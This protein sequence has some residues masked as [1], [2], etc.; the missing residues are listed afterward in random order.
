MNNLAKLLVF[1]FMLSGCATKE[2]VHEYVQSQLKPVNNRTVV[3]ENRSNAADAAI[4][5]GAAG[6]DT[7][8]KRLDDAV[9]TLRVHADRLSRNEADIAQLSRTAQEAL[10]RA[11]A[12][13]KLAAGKMAFEVALSEDKVKFDLNKAQLSK[14]AMAALDE[15][16]TKIKAENRIVHV[17]IQGHTDSI[18]SEA[19]NL[20][21]GQQRADA[22]RRY[23]YSKGGLPLHRLSAMS[24]GESVPIA[25]N[26]NRAGRAQNRRVVLVVLY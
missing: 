25:T 19:V 23:L 22:V 26:M 24:Y 18:G 3:L 4:K 16:F 1:A 20:R 7:T 13:G 21:V 2:Y 6:L 15:V 17:E 10:E 8:S 14:E 5:S 9:I 11:I 12:A